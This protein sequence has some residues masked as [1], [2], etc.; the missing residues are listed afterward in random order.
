MRPTVLMIDDHAGFR[1]RARA[2]LEAEGYDVVG[3]AADGE[4]GLVAADRLRPDIAIVD[5]GL[6]GLDGFGVAERLRSERL[7]VAIVL[8]SGRDR[9]DFGDRV[10]QS[11]ADGFIAKADLSGERLRTIVRS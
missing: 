7:A 3:E 11:A 5:I 6:P 1:S 2:M 9:V 4:A 8:V 10:E